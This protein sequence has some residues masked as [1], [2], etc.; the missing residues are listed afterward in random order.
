MLL[1]NG[2]CLSQS[3]EVDAIEAV[4]VFDPSDYFTPPF[5]VVSETV[6]S[7]AI[8]ETGPS[9]TQIKL[10]G[11][12]F[13]VGAVEVM[14]NGVAGVSVEVIN[15]T[16]LLVTVPGLA[17]GPVD[18][19]VNTSGGTATLPGEPGGFEVAVLTAA[20]PTLLEWGIGLLMIGLMCAGIHHLWAA[21]NK[22]MV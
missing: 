2:E 18:I 1:I 14:F 13:S 3:D 8:P 20:I 15:D 5:Q 22:R 7:F 21:R 10:I 17:P 6:V 16:T 19:T 12:G 9:G 4:D 11:K